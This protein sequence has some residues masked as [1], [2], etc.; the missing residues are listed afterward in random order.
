MRIIGIDLGD[1]RTGIA[2]SD[3]TEFLAS[4]LCTV[5]ANGKRALLEIIS[6]KAS[7]LGAGG[8]VVGDPVNMDGTRG[9][10]SLKAHAFAERL[11]E[12]TG[13]P[14]YL[15]DERCSTKVA[16]SIMNLTDTRGKKRKKKVDTL[17]AEII[18]QDFLDRRRA[19]KEND[20]RS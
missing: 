8:F 17:S 9:D 15:S 1:V 7:E 12:K 5:R 4:G 2:V 11:A 14:V 16:H 6:E 13:L 20:P 18:L 10:S 3:E 19:E